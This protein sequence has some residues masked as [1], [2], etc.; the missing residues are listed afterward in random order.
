M[1]T[2]YGQVLVAL[3]LQADNTL[4]YV[5]TGSRQE[6][7]RVASTNVQALLRARHWVVTLTW[8][9]QRMTLEVRDQDAVHNE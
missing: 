9:T 1:E 2:P 8:N 5:R 7:T 4:G 3:N 6:G